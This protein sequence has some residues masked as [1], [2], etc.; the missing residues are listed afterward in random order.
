MFNYKTASI[1]AYIILASLIVLNLFTDIGYIPYL[2]LFLLCGGVIFYGSAFVNSGFYFKMIC[3][4]KTNEKVLALTFDDGPTNVTPLILDVLKEYNVPATFFTVGSRVEKNELII[5]RM[6]RQGHLIGN[7]SY[8]HNFWFAN[9]SVK[10]IRNELIETDNIIEKYTSKNVKLF[11]PPYGVTNPT[12]NRAIKRMNY[13]PIGWSLKS[14][15]TVIESTKKIG[16]RLR[17][18]LKPGDIIL[19]HDT[20]TKVIIVLKEFLEY[21]LQNGYRIVRLDALLN[22]DGYK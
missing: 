17:K 9:Y 21:A 22:V 15:D 8:S 14:R 4:A 7:H 2:V 10:K 5:K 11:R 18:K 19:L 6:D 3:S 20:D 16:S 1:S 13:I 12:I